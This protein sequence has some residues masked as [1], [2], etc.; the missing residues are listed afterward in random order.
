MQTIQR[1][2]THLEWANRQLLAS[3][4]A[5]QADEA[6]K[7]ATLFWHILQAER[8]WLI[9]LNGNS[10]EGIK[11]WE[12]RADLAACSELIEANSSGYKA[13]LD[14]LP[15]AELDRVIDYR[16]QAG[17]PFQTSVR[18]ILIHVALHGQYHRGQINTALRAGGFPPA[19][20]DYILYSRLLDQV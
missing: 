15:E 19:A 10:S 4:Q 7:A 8:V 3:L 5:A 13:W 12:D 2:F 11:I 16:S 1:M 20:L 9:R 14:A 17:A 18:D 6:G